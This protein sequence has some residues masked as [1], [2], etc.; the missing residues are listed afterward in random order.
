MMSRMKSRRRAPSRPGSKSPSR[1]EPYGRSL[2]PIGMATILPHTAQRIR[3]LEDVLL[4]TLG[5]WGYQEII[6]P[7]FE[8]LD[9]L[10]EGLEPNLIEKSYKFADRTTGRILLLR[11]DVT[12]QI[13]RI[14]AMGIFGSSLP[15]RLSY[16]TTVFR[17]EP[18]HAGREREIF[19]VGAELIG[20]DDVT[21]DAEIIALMIECLKQLGL[22]DFKVSLGHVGFFKALLVRSG[23]SREGQ[24]RAERAAARKDL[25]HLEEI[26]MEE[27]VSKQPA[28]AIL[29]APELCG[30]E[31]VLKRGRVLA[32]GDARLREAL[33]RLSRLYQVLSASGLREHLL[34][35]L[36]EFRGFDYYDGV[37]FDVFAGSLG[38]E[39]GGGGR[40]NHLIGRF[41]RDLPST[42]F[43]LDVDRLFRA[44]EPSVNGRSGEGSAMR[45]D[46]L[47]CGPLSVADRVLQVAQLLRQ[48]G[49][50]VIQAMLPGA[51]I[52]HA[53]QQARRASAAAVVM[54]G[55]SSLSS[56][57]ALVLTGYAP[58]HDSSA[59][60]K[61]STLVRRKMK[62]QDLPT[63]SLRA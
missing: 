3:H 1:R 39:L 50:R 51:S 34:L 14:V 17:H 16:R 9:V 21:M 63:M 26:L 47:V 59:R 41:G 35:D 42:G 36:G 29:E 52:Q 30:R 48:A 54:L 15:L 4:T 24:K 58:E 33:D 45:A 55:T 8:Y 61:A 22:V 31:E 19:Q 27:Q 57:Q 20:Q 60:G 23:M 12:A 46:F 32:R 7:T 37:V 40:Y 5:R 38:C 43:A 49:H 2:V 62:V 53:I 56:D 10:S 11:P 6:P 25:P 28:A 13:A 44:L 18:E